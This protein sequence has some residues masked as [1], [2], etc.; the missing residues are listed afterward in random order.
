M[1]GDRRRV[2]PCHE[3]INLL[4]QLQVESFEAA[5]DVQGLREPDCPFTGVF[6]RAPVRPLS[7]NPLTLLLL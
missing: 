5:L 2:S 6:I 7:P 1:D 4:E 3:V